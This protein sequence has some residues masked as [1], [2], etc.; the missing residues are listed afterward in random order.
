MD[1]KDEILLH[2]RGRMLCSMDCM[3]RI[4]GFQ[5][6]PAPQPSVMHI[7]AKLPSQ[8]LLLQ[9]EQKL[10]D[11][12]VYLERP[13]TIEFEEMLYTDFFKT[14]KYGYKLPAKHFSKPLNQPNGDVH[15]IPTR[16]VKP[17]Y[18]F[19]REKPEDII[20]RMSVNYIQHG[21]I[22]YLRRLLL[23][24]ATYS[25]ESLKT[26]K[27]IS[28]QTFQEAAVKRGL[29]SDETEAI[30]CFNESIQISTPP[31]LRQ[32]FVTMTLQGF[33][34]INIYNDE[35]LRKTMYIDYLDEDNFHSEIHAN[36]KLLQYISDKLTAEAR[37]NSD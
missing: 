36:N 12:L 1:E 18:I 23:N 34:T 24:V 25:L 16:F 10:C 15:L 7:K 6:Y 27:Y 20:V 17:L 8:L 11:L 29:V 3:W 19:K 30:D 2:I 32:L 13:Q 37:C 5:N 21:E 22:W 26:V 33:T 31:L 9:N 4:F 14:W 28:Y 35:R